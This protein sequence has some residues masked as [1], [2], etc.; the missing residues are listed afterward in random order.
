MRRKGARVSR[1][2]VPVLLAMV[3]HSWAAV[4]AGAGDYLL[5][6][7]Q[8]GHIN[9]P[10]GVD[11]PEERTLSSIEVVTRPELPFHSRV[12]IGSSSLDLDGRLE[13]IDE[14]RFQ[15]TIRV[16]SSE[17]RDP[18][19]AQDSVQ[20]QIRMSVGERV[21]LGGADEVRTGASRLSSRMRYFAVLTRH[22]PLATDQPTDESANPMGTPTT[23]PFAVR[24]KAPSPGTFGLPPS[25][26]SP[27][28]VRNGPPLEFGPVLQ[29]ELTRT[30]RMIDARAGVFRPDPAPSPVELPTGSVAIPRIERRGLE[31]IRVYVSDSLALVVNS[32]R[33]DVVGPGTRLDGIAIPAGDERFTWELPA[34][35]QFA[36]LSPTG[37]RVGL[38][39]TSPARPSLQQLSNHDVNPDPAAIS[40]WEVGGDGSASRVASFDPGGAPRWIEFADDNLVL[41]LVGA[42]VRAFELPEGRSVW[43]AVIGS[44]RIPVIS[45]GRQ[46]LAVRSDRGITAIDSRSGDPVAQLVADPRLG[47]QTALSFS[48]D[49]SRLA[50][51]VDRRI[52]IWDL[53]TEDV[54]AE[55]PNYGGVWGGYVD[56]H[57][58][59]SGERLIDDRTGAIIWSFPGLRMPAPETPWPWLRG[60]F[61]QVEG[62]PL[63]PSTIPRIVFLDLLTPT[64][65]EAAH[66]PPTESPF[67]FR[68]P[69]PVAIRV[70]YAD[71]E[72]AEAALRTIEQRLK[73]A[74][75][76]VQ[77]DA[78]FKLVVQVEDGPKF[79]L[80]VESTEKVGDRERSVT[81]ER[82]IVS[83]AVQ[84][85]LLDSHGQKFFEQS[86][87]YRPFPL[88][89]A[90]RASV[91]QAVAEA[92]RVTP[93]FFGQ[94]H[95]PQEILKPEMAGGQGATD[96]RSPPPRRAHPA[97]N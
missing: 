61:W 21:R 81:E 82:S 29:P 23:H 36:A 52:Q 26:D 86:L 80:R 12:V 38:T 27:L 53:E 3:A 77:P 14:G 51:F 90:P 95:L 46:Q 42:E 85:S 73:D 60:R 13:A 30:R 91:E 96:V 31:P 75:F 43:R 16:L 5:R 97:A 76:D 84:A 11:L 56:D 57:L 72:R 44:D 4:V 71:T 63:D 78:P 17:L 55:I 94:I 1:I 9:Q 6:V 58:L 54:L 19:P 65:L 67:A 34:G 28:E 33:H 70:S 15:V 83:K 25:D 18:V 8:I 92:L 62:D 35:V 68:A 40:V 45:P 47:W 49:G 22:R 48:P 2:K 88:R 69:G 39:W 10:D 74:G 20:T 64:V 66:H 7:E 79:D 93:D 89:V 37:K 87:L 24:P 59:L 50:S 41:A 32:T